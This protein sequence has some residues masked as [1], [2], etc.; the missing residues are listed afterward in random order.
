MC[1]RYTLDKKYLKRAEE[2]ASFILDH[3]TLSADGIPFWDFDHPDIPYTYKDVSAA[4]IYA[5]ALQRLSGLTTDDA[6]SARYRASAERMILSMIRNYKAVEDVP[7]LLDHSVGDLPQ[8]SEV[9]VPIN[10]ADY[11]FMESLYLYRLTK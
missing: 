10:Y 8:A 7:F 5:S 9:D 11:Y 2:V 4:G 3:P 1:Y 6:K